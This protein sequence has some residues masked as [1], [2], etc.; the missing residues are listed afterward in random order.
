M[1]EEGCVSVQQD[2]QCSTVL[3]PV[4]FSEQYI[5]PIK[6]GACSGNGLGLLSE[7]RASQHSDQG[8]VSFIVF[9]GQASF[10]DCCFE[11]LWTEKQGCWLLQLRFISDLFKHSAPTAAKSVSTAQFVHDQVGGVDCH[12][13]PVCNFVA[14]HRE[15]DDYKRNQ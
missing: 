11:M 7:Q 13:S 10:L 3:R 6:S 1:M 8:L 4:L 2:C 12:R 5:L 14:E 9:D 15:S